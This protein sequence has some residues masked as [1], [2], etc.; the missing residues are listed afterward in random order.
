MSALTAGAVISAGAGSGLALRGFSLPATLV[1]GLVTE[2]TYA[3]LLNTHPEWMPR[4]RSYGTREA[5]VDITSVFVGWSFAKA[6]QW[7]TQG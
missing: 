4:H 6:L 3:A 5:T 2:V 7:A 1:F